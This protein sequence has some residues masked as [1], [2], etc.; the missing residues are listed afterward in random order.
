VT[1]CPVCGQE[2]ADDRWCARG[3]PQIKVHRN[4]Y[5][6]ANYWPNIIVEPCHPILRAKAERDTRIAN[7]NSEDAL[8]WNV[9]RS[10][11]YLGLTGPV[12]GQ[13]FGLGR[14]ATIYY[15][16]YPRSEP[17]WSP[18]ADA[19]HALEPGPRR[20]HSEPD[21]VLVDEAHR[22]FVILEPKFGSPVTGNRGPDWLVAKEYDQNR[23]TMIRR[24]YALGDPGSQLLK[25]WEDSMRQGFYQLTRQMLFGNYIGQQHGYTFHLYS[26]ISPGTNP[27][28]E[29][30][31]RTFQGL[32]TTAG[33]EHYGWLTWRQVYDAI[34][35]NAD[36]IPA[37]RRKHLDTLGCYLRDKT[38]N[39]AP[40]DL[41]NSGKRR[42][43]DD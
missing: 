33:Q 3:H 4:T 35:A 1:V 28:N 13:L 22:R 9:F 18:Y 23:R 29:G 20:R 25:S 27:D 10:I 26:L 17:L 11:E 31:C 34:V 12:L 39:G 8:T 15:W 43:K 5:V 16:M 21:L 41:L 2:V 14:E 32:L 36:R 6:Y 24:G 37:D 19:W 38:F 42:D 40:A 30:L 7:E